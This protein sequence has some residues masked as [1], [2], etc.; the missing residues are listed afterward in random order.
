MGHKLVEFGRQRIRDVD[1]L[2][3]YLKDVNDPLLNLRQPS[4]YVNV[5]QILLWLPF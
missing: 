1:P 5:W 2:I 4:F 3:V